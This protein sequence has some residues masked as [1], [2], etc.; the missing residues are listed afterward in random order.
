MKN[1][2]TIV[3]VFMAAGMIFLAGVVAFAGFDKDLF[4]LGD[5]VI[6]KGSADILEDGGQP[7]P[8]WAV[9]FEPYS[10][11]EGIDWIEKDTDHNGVPDSVQLYNGLTAVFLADDLAREGTD[12]TSFATS[13]K[14][15]MVIADWE[16]GTGKVTPKDDI[17]NAYAFAIMDN[18][19]TPPHL[20]VYAGVERI[21]TEGDSHIDI[22][23]NQDLIDTDH[24]PPCPTKTCD[25]I[26][27]KMHGDILI[28]M[29]FVQGGRLGDVEVRMWDTTVPPGEFVVKSILP[30]DAEGSAEGCNTDGGVAPDTVCAVNNGV[31]ILGGPWPHYDVNENVTTD[32]IPMNGF[33][34]VGVD[35]TELIGFTPCLKT[36]QV[37]SRTAASF[38]SQL[39]DFVLGNFDICGS[40]E[41][42][43]DAIPDD[44]Q[45]FDFNLTGPDLFDED[46]TLDDY[47]ST[48][49]PNSEKFDGLLA[50]SYTAT[51]YEPPAGW[52]FVNLSCFSNHP[53]S[54]PITGRTADIDLD[55]GEDVTCIWTNLKLGTIIVKKITD[56][57]T[58]SPAFDFR[59]E[60][61]TSIDFDLLDLQQETFNDLVPGV[62]YVS[63]LD[64]PLGWDFMG[65][66]IEE[67]ILA[68]STSV[69]KDATVNLEPGETA[70]LTYHNR[71]RGNITIIKDAIPDDA[72]FFNYTGSFGIF[73]LQDNGGV[74][75][76]DFTTLV[77]G[78]Y[79]VTELLPDGWVFDNCTCV[80][81]TGN[82][83][84]TGATADIELDPGENVTCTYTN[85]KKGR[86]ITDKVT[87]PSG[88]SQSFQYSSSWDTGFSLTDAA[89]PNDSGLLAPG[90]Y[91]VAET[92]PNNW[93][94][95]NL[96]TSDPTGDTTVLGTAATVDL[97]PGETVR[98]TYTNTKKGSITVV[99]EAVP[100]T[101]ES[102]GFTGDLGG[103]SLVDNGG[104]NY[105]NFT[106]IVPGTYHVSESMPLPLDYFL[107]DITFAGDNGN[108]SAAGAT[109]T[110]VVDPGEN[111]IVTFYNAV[112]SEGCTPGYWKNHPDLWPA[113]WTPESLFSDAFGIDPCIPGGAGMTL[114]EALNLQGGGK[115]ALTRHAAAAFLNAERPEVDSYPSWWVVE[116]YVAACNNSNL[117]SG[118]LS[119]FVQVNE[120]CCPCNNDSCD[121]GCQSPTP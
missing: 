84:I 119:A 48:E 93:I 116:M 33:T 9:L 103:F 28:S 51:E 107:N 69:D 49:M 16:W 117:V 4:E 114:M 74:N 19:F 65:V 31:P 98:L 39:K 66:D 106:G 25:F 46:V 95:T 5:G 61:G 83:V 37:K 79:T 76:A 8:D 54:I 111:I 59:F 67:N 102:F 56:P 45:T 41:L 42:V 11:A 34:E 113:P 14:N 52:M 81:P 120:S 108:S 10:T 87:R 63:E 30:H 32:P 57:P 89:P 36:I 75:F 73:Q 55:F 60:N 91:V 70:T 64:L 104:V 121:N 118:T 43:K 90:T 22:E 23:L 1:K 40:I 2:S 96:S 29:N 99:K 53:G 71:A 26:G 13:N 109:A 94:F 112:P 47:T 20:I 24:T 80:D 68:N 27:E 17:S 35:I 110:I 7:G 92:V 88:D 38:T 18:N 101:P 105:L 97:A 100:Q 77:P 82:T 85:L 78:P 58:S 72:Q 15:D 3:A 6:T 86:I 62:Y 50:G 44:P 12:D 115:K 21:K